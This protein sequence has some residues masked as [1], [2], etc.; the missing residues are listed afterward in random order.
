MGSSDRVMV[1]ADADRREFLAFAQYF[2]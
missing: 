2:R 1:V